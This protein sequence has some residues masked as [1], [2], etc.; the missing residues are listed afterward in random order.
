MTAQP[1]YIDPYGRPTM[2]L[3]NRPRAVS[4]C[5]SAV[6]GASPRRVSRQRRTPSATRPTTLPAKI[7]KDSV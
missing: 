4:T 3:D 1:M 7:G 2:E 6:Y 5:Y